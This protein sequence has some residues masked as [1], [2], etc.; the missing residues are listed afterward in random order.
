MKKCEMQSIFPSKKIIE[1][2]L[3]AINVHASCEWVWF[4]SV[5][6][7][8]VV[9]GVSLVGVFWALHE[10][11]PSSMT[12]EWRLPVLRWIRCKWPGDVSW[13]CKKWKPTTRRR[14][15]TVL[16]GQE[17]HYFEISKSIHAILPCI[18][19]LRQGRLYLPVIEYTAWTCCAIKFLQDTD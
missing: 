11:N 16:L 3:D 4:G 17:F 1:G 5:G 18:I 2:I 8:P 10:V 6:R 19:S 15:W 13:Q 12:C 7:H 9:D 14:D